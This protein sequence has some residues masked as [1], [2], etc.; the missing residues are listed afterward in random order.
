MADNGASDAFN[1]YEANDIWALHGQDPRVNINLPTDDLAMQGV[2]IFLDYKF[3]TESLI[4]RTLN[5]QSCLVGFH[6]QTLCIPDILS[7]QLRYMQPKGRS[8]NAITAWIQWAF[9][10]LEKV[11]Q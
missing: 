6:L 3:I 2:R 10:K 9:L 5:V 11:R 4:R 8:M 1:M 7:I